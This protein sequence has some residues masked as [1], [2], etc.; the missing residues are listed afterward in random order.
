VVGL[1]AVVQPRVG[2]AGLPRVGDVN[3]RHRLSHLA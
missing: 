3:K 1:Y 2:L